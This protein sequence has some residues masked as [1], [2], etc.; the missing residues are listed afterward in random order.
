[1]A[2][3]YGEL[4]ALAHMQE[5]LGRPAEGAALLAEAEKVQ[6]R[7]LALLWHPGMQFLGTFKTP[8]PAAQA[9]LASPANSRYCGFLRQGLHMRLM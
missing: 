7:V 4:V 3:Q 1:M 5:L 2:A 6:T 9:V 8:A